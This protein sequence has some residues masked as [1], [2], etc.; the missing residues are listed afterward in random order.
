MG[1]YDNRI[2]M[3]LEKW[4]MRSIHLQQMLDQDVGRML[5]DN[6]ICEKLDSEPFVDIY[7]V[8]AQGWHV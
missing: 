3:I 7:V 4:S 8:L 6:G 1:V 5:R 2:K